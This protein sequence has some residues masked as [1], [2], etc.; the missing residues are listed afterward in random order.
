M[1]GQWEGRRRGTG[2]RRHEMGGMEIGLEGR[3]ERGRKREINTYFSPEKATLL[4]R[5]K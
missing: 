2:D 5:A 4:S 1:E 3:R